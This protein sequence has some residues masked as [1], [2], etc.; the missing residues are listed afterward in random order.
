[1]PLIVTEEATYSAALTFYPQIETLKKDHLEL[2]SDFLANNF[3]VIFESGKFW[4]MELKSLFSLLYKKDMRFVFCPHG[5]S[6]K[7]HSIKTP[8]EQDLSLVYGDHMIDLLT[9]TRAIHHISAFARTGNYRLPFYLKYKSFYDS[10]VENQISCKIDRTKKVILYAPTWQDGENPSSFFTSTQNLIEELK[11]DF[12]LI[13]K[14]HPFL[15]E[16]HP[17]HTYYITSLYENTPGV[18]FLKNFPSI[19]PLLQIC[20]LYIGDYSSIGYD[21]LSFNKP[22]YFLRGKSSSYSMLHPCG[23]VIPFTKKINSFIQDT[24]EF[25][26]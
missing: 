3:D 16:F 23:L 26:Q 4:A 22:L 14:L 20:D 6:D 24:L 2:S 9:K 1:M 5:N 19:Y 18:T 8:T 25:N 11:D 21:F 17:A 15:E 10:L 7:G 13:I 12:N